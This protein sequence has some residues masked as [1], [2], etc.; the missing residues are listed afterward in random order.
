MY[1][2]KHCNIKEWNKLNLIPIMA[3][4]AIIGVGILLY[5]INRKG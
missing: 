1:K 4:T 3:G 5:C 2:P